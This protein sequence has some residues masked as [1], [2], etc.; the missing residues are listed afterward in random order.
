[1]RKAMVTAALVVAFWSRAEADKPFLISGYDD[2]LRQAENANVARAAGRSM[3][4]AEGFAGMP[5]LY[6]LL[7]DS[8]AAVPFVVVSATSTMFEGGA[9]QFLQHSG[10]PAPQLYFRRW[11]L[12]SSAEKFKYERFDEIIAQQTAQQ[13]DRHFIFVFDNSNTSLD[14]S[15]RLL[16]E[17]ASAVSAIY[18]RETLKRDHL[19]D[20]ITFITAFEIAAHEYAVGRMTEAEVAQVASAIVREQRPTRVVPDY[21]YCPF[22]FDPCPS[23]KPALADS[24]ASVR[25]KVVGICKSRQKH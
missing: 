19:A 9:K 13:A 3:S 20:T 4:D 14:L 17:R 6:Q 12:D 24:C 10:F 16:R 5:E 1:M 23:A 21:A 15:E 22:D 8:Q 25:T 11:L 7:S 2:V 18:I